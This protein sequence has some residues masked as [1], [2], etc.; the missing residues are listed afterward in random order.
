MD[1]AVDSNYCVELLHL[2]LRALY[3]DELS[4]LTAELAITYYYC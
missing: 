2:F 4:I 3:N 1:F